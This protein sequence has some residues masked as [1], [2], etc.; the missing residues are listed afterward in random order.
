[1][2]TMKSVTEDRYQEHKESTPDAIERVQGEITKGQAAL[3]TVESQVANIESLSS[4]V[5]E[6]VLLPD[7]KQQSLVLKI[8]LN[9]LEKLLA[10][11]KTQLLAED[12][13]NLIESCNKYTGDIRTVVQELLYTLREPMATAFKLNDL[14]FER[15]KLHKKAAEASPGDNRLQELP[16]QIGGVIQDFLTTAAIA[17]GITKY[18][19]KVYGGDYARNAL[20]ALDHPGALMKI[21]EDIEHAFLCEWR[22]ELRRL[23]ETR[24][25]RERRAER[26]ATRI[27]SKPIIVKESAQAKTD[28]ILDAR[29]REKDKADKELADTMMADAKALRADMGGKQ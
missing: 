28:V 16:T 21:V 19:A 15:V 22:D 8:Q 7:L 5:E 24:D 14:W 25:I 17:T 6:A 29:K 13:T 2:K 27:T 11:L 9:N 20:G 18:Y 26:A 3:V 10:E 23:E 12:T 4:T 1:M